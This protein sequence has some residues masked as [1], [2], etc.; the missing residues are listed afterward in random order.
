MSRSVIMH[1]NNT[2]HESFPVLSLLHLSWPLKA[3]NKAGHKQF[4]TKRKWG[5]ET[6]QCT[7]FI[8]RNIPYQSRLLCWW[9]VHRQ[10][11]ELHPDPP[12]ST[13][14]CQTARQS[15]CCPNKDLYLCCCRLLLML[16]VMNHNHRY[17]H[18]S[19][20]LDDWAPRWRSDVRTLQQMKPLFNRA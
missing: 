18:C 1:E 12:P 6:A 9:R 15:N 17:T 20:M 2:P 19:R 13:D 8:Y 4:E 7:Y 10:Q 14:C 16:G 5:A 11:A 3:V